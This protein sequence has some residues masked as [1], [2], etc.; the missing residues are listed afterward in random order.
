MAT[1]RKDEVIAALTRLGELAQSKGEAVELLLLGG[2][3]MVLLFGV[4][5]NTKDIDVVILAPAESARVRQLAQL[6]ADEKNWPHDWLNDAAKGFIRNATIGPIVFDAP[7]ITVFRPEIEQLLAMKLSA[8]RDDVD[9]AD[10]RR[11]LRELVGTY[12]DVWKSVLPHLQPGRELTAKYA[13]DDLWDEL[14]DAH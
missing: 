2:A 4:R 1:L 13:F 12:D 8:W 6:V 10:A 5:E 3:L 9:I 14:H 7:G 11:L